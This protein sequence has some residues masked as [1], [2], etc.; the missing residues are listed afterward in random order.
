MSRSLIAAF[1]V[2]AL[3][4]AGAVFYAQWRS[5]AIRNLTLTPK[6]NKVLPA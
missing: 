1:I 3:M 5:D 2:G 6:A 4:V